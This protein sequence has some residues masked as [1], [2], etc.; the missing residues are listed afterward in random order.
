MVYSSVVEFESQIEDHEQTILQN[1]Q[2][3]VRKSKEIASEKKIMEPFVKKLGKYEAQQKI[4]VMSKN[5]KRRMIRLRDNIEMT[6][7]LIDF[8]QERIDK[9]QK[10]IKIEE[11]SMEMK[12]YVV[13]SKKKAMRKTRSNSV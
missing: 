12:K 11:A 7:V 2:K 10:R 1:W 6:Q 9:A 8:N 5:E 4:R 3:T 13:Q